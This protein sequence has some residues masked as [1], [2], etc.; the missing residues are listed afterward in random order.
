MK[1]TLEY[2][3]PTVSHCDVAVFINGALTGVLTMR[4][5]EIVDFQHIIF[6]GPSSSID[7]T[8]ACGNP[9]PAPLLDQGA[10]DE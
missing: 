6:Y 8:M 10:Y 1:I 5:V 9:D 4:Q 3:N 2:R 7:K